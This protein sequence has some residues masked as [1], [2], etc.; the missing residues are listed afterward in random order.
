MVPSGEREPA[1]IRHIVL[2]RFR[3]DVP[4]EARQNLRDELAGLEVGRQG[5]AAAYQGFANEN[6]DA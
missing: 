3:A 4:P 2:I 5:G 1:M 6:L